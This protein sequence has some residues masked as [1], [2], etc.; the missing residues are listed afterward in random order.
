MANLSRANKNPAFKSFD[1]S[2]VEINFF[3][4]MASMDSGKVRTVIDSSTGGKVLISEKM[5]MQLVKAE[6]SFW[7]DAEKMQKKKE[8]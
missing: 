7:K 8:H 2:G 6:D 4:V 5:Y 1:L 3:E